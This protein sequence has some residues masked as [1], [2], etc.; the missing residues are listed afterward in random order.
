MLSVD[1]KIVAKALAIRLQEVMGSVIHVDQTCGVRCR[2]CH[3][4][5]ALIRD[6]I[7]WVEQKNLPLVI[8]SVDE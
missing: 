5:L 3:M 6:V 8:L 7:S 1:T 2:S 4:N